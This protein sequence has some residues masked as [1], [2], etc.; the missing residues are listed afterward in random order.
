MTGLSNTEE[1][2]N[3]FGRKAPWLLGERPDVC[4]RLP[5][6]GVRRLYG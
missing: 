6:R 1:K 5:V 2:F 3:S 4:G